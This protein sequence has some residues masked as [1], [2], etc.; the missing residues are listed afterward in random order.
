MAQDEARARGHGLSVHHIVPSRESHDNSGQNLITLC[1]SYH[2]KAEWKLGD[3]KQGQH[4]MAIM[5]A[6]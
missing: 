6:A 3:R 4:A 2:L 5:D 1:Q